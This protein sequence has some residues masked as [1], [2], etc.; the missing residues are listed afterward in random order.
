[1]DNKIITTTP[2]VETEVE[3][4]K[5]IATKV[6]AAFYKIFKRICH[7]KKMK[8]YEVVQIMAETF[9][10]YTDDRHNL[11]AE[12]ERLMMSFEH[13]EGWKDCFN[14]AEVSDTEKEIETAIYIMRARGK[15]GER[16]VMVNRPWM[17]S[18]FESYNVVD[19][20]ERTIES[21]MPERYMR[22]RSLAAN[23]GFNSILDL[24][25]HFIDVHSKDSDIAAFR[26]F[27][28]D[29]AR[30]DNA[31]PVEYGQKRKSTHH[32]DIDGAAAQKI[33]NFTNEPEIENNNEQETY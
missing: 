8:T 19:I 15:N 9:V 29:S 26:Q 30:A 2:E 6:S 17:Q 3:R 25:D 7:K 32:R 13:M 23:L 21:T 33:I 5:V 24:L 4:Y 27:F 1:M 10:R 16:V 12:I 11:S 14:L 18:W 22:L 31:K 20:L 28:E